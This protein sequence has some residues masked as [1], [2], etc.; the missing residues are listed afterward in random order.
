[1]I[2]CWGLFLNVALYIF[3]SLFIHLITCFIYNHVYLIFSCSCFNFFVFVAC[4]FFDYRLLQ[5]IK[6]ILFSIESFK[7]TI[8]SLLFSSDENPKYHWNHNNSI[9][10]SVNIFL[11]F[12]SLLLK[13]KRTIEYFRA[14]YKWGKWNVYRILFFLSSSFFCSP[15]M[16]NW[17]FK[18]FGITSNPLIFY[19]FN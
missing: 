8:F 12:F 17:I 18:R 3:L 6:I 16:F 14:F 13:R 15:L 19:S 10:V 4:F 11:L 7:N 5:R 2:Y 9:T 1:M